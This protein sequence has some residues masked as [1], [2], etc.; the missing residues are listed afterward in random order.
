MGEGRGRDLT[1][2]LV[3]ECLQSSTTGPY[4]DLARHLKS[5]ALAV[6]LWFLRISCICLEE[7]L[8]CVI[9]RL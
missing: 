3:Y 9:G 4:E 6:G 8:V 2:A 7:V 1:N 5:I